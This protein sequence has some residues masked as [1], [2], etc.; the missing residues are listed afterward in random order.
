[1]RQFEALKPRVELPS[2]GYVII[3]PTEA[4]TVVDVNS[5]SFTRS[6]LPE[7]QSYGHARRQQKLLV[8]TA[9]AE[10][11]RCDYSRFH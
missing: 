8:S 6:Q 10:S 9:A 5:G 11:G 4:L 2:G 7:K 3:E 1:M